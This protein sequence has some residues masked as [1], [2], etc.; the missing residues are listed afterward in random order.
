MELAAMIW[1]VPH[2]V[3]H[4]LHTTTG[5]RHQ[6]PHRLEVPRTGA[7]TNGP[8][9]LHSLEGAHPIARLGTGMVETTDF[10][11]WVI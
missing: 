6:R 4:H 2:L 11:V 3:V 8:S 10:L 5:H 1:V 9:I 7:P